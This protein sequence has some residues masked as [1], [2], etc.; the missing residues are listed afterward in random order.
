MVWEDKVAV[1]FDRYRVVNLIAQGLDNPPPALPTTKIPKP[2][3]LPKPQRK[4]KADRPKAKRAVSKLSMTVSELKER[5]R[6][7][8][9]SELCPK[10]G[11]LLDGQLHQITCAGKSSY[12]P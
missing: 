1:Y 5:N 8:A 3:P 6:R 9:S 12:D 7:V 10:C 2:P 11:H 4:R